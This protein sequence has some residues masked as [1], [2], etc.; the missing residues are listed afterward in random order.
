MTGRSTGPEAI[1]RRDE[2]PPTGPVIIFD[3]DSH[4]YVLKDQAVA[5]AWWEMPDEYT[6]G[7]DALARP[8]RMTGEPHRVRLELTRADPDEAELRRMVA[9]HYRRHRRGETPPQATDLSEY[10]TALPCEGL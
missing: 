2:T 3:D 9:E 6:C 8:L 4:M 5:E 1:S 7:F 10:V